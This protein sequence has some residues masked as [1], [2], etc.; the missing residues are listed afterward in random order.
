M[1]QPNTVRP[2]T[3]SIRPLRSGLIP[4]IVHAGGALAGDGIEKILRVLPDGIER[5]IT[6]TVMILKEGSSTANAELSCRIPSSVKAN[7]VTTSINFVGDLLGGA[8]NNLAH[9]IV[10]PAGCGEQNLARFAPTLIVHIYMEATGHLTPQIH[11]T[12]VSYAQQGLQKHLTLRRPNGAFRFFSDN[13]GSTWVT[14]FSVKIFRQA[15]TF[16]TIDE[17]LIQTALAF[18]MT[19]QEADGGFSEDDTSRHY[20]YQ[21]G[22]IGKVSVTAYIAILLTQIQDDYPQYTTNRDRAIAFISSSVNHN[23][24]YELAITCYA[25]YLVDHPTF[26]GKYQA[27]LSK[28]TETSELMFWQLN[29]GV[30][31]DVEI[32]SYALLFISKFDINRSIKLARYIISKKNANSGWASTQDTVMAVESLASVAILIT[33]YDGEMEIMAWPNAGMPLSVNINSVNLMTLQSYNLDSGVRSVSLFARG[34]VTA[35]A[36]VSFT[37]RYFENLDDI[38]PRFALNYGLVEECNTPLRMRICIN[39]IPDGADQ[40]SNMVIMRMTLPS[41]YLYDSDTELPSVIRVSLKNHAI[42]LE[43][44]L[45]YSQKLD[46][47]NDNTRIIAYFDSMTSEPVC[48]TI[49]A[50]HQFTV[51]DDAGLL[52]GLMEVID[53]YSPGEII[54]YFIPKQF[55]NL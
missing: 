53:Y 24:A 11:N 31:L 43:F 29:N 8:L 37:C 23:N 41:G 18:I 1:S 51:S 3:I 10:Q 49:T 38:P 4:I 50:F 46:I 54:D 2:F 12:I 6:N 21:G 22:I 13:Q 55:G 5:V 36:I 14:A 9:L 26:D 19:K 15:Q 52:R 39:Y 45:N 44:S 7:T 33:K 16:M 47:E 34:P 25:L 30:V 32:A 48:F 20:R 42:Y 27:L 28:A 35:K 17:Q 40:R